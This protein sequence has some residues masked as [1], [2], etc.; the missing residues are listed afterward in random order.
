MRAGPPSRVALLTTAIRELARSS[1]DSATV[2]RISGEAVGIANAPAAPPTASAS[3]I[4]Q[5]AGEPPSSSAPT[6]SWV[7]HRTRSVVSATVRALKRSPTTPPSGSRSS[8]GTIAQP[9]TRASAPV[10]PVAR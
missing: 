10:E 4:C 8:L 7:A 9:S 1:P 6:K 2:P 5:S 3:A